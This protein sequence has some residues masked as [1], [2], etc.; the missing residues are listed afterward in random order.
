MF[1]RSFR[2]AEQLQET[3]APLQQETALI[4]NLSDD[5]HLRRTILLDEYT[6]LRISVVFQVTLGYFL[7]QF[8]FGQAGCL[9]LARD[10]RHPYCSIA[11]HANIVARKIRPIEDANIEH[12]AWTN[13]VAVVRRDRERIGERLLVRG[14][15]I[16]V[17][18]RRWRRL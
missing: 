16:L 9:N 17:S 1:R 15:E 18:W 10:Q 5:R 14:G 4:V 2:K 11:F 13:A 3:K 8:A 12:V 7:L 6:H